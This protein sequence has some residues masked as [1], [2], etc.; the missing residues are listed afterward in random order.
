MSDPRE[1]YD[2][3][4]RE[5]YVLEQLLSWLEQARTEPPPQDEPEQEEGQRYRR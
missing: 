5:P 4:G 1:Q 3:A 2:L